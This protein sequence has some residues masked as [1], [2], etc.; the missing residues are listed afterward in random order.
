MHSLPSS[1][2]VKLPRA[3]LFDYD[4][5]LVSSELIH[6][7]AWK[8][9]LLK[10]KLPLD[11]QLL[12]ET[13]GKTAPQT[14]KILL[15]KFHPGWTERDFN[16]QELVQ[17]K[18]NIYL[19]IAEKELQ[20]YPGVV[21]GLEWLKAAKIPAAVVSNAR[22]LDLETTIR[23]LGIFH[24][25]EEVI[26]R[27]DVPA[28]KPDPTPYLFAAASLG[29]LPSDCLA[30]EDSPT[31]LE[32]ALL[33]KVPVAAVMTNFSENVLSQPVPGRPDL[34]PIWVGASLEE[35]FRWLRTLLR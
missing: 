28:A 31:G 6:L 24:Y 4:G 5:V 8:Q 27:D 9:L 13:A 11:L 35:F 12:H 18:S 30:I 29:F 19:P 2:K 34:K 26:S 3:V 25:F 21:D 1:S 22:K 15:D 20:L 33:A 32:A 17:L 16:I 10:L 14:L 7:S 23:K